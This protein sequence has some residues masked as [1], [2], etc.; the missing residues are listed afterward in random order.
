MDLSRETPNI[1]DFNIIKLI[2]EGISSKVFLVEKRDTNREYAMKVIAKNLDKALLER[3]IL[4]DLHHPF[5]A[6]LSYSFQ[7]ETQL[8]IV[9]PYCEYGDLFDFMHDQKQRCFST[10]QT[11]YYASC[12][13]LALEYL[14]SIG[15]IYR[16]LKLENILMNSSGHILLTDFGLSVY[17]KNN[18]GPEPNNIMN[19]I[20]GT[21]EYLAPEIV[22]GQS[23]TCIV[24]WWSFG[25]LIYE[26]L[27]GYPP[28]CSDDTEVLF[29]LIS[30][31]DLSS[32]L[33]RDKLSSK[34]KSIIKKLLKRNPSKR[35]GSNGAAEIK[36]HSFFSDVDFQSLCYEKP[37][38]F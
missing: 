17:D 6:T 26:M 22:D 25:I 9:M 36:D 11:V 18:P 32:R 1:R 21:P 13:L 16:D 29:K 28:F 31:C 24:D 15:V 5:V 34:A 4:M 3:D 37:P 8:Y 2:G 38:T 14:H 23:Y 12:T 27:H 10:V 19:D 7:N 33:Q 20:V 35:L 30:K